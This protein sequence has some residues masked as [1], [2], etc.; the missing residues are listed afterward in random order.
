MTI[1][2]FHVTI[3]C[4]LQNYGNDENKFMDSD[5]N[6]GS[7][8]H[9]HYPSRFATKEYVDQL[10]KHVGY[11]SIHSHDFRITNEDK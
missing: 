8:R 7:P 9:I 11:V 5:N 2:T 6:N 10:W 3:M 4:V 1:S